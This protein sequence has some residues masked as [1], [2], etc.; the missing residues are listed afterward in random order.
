MEL[1]FK[2]KMYP[3]SKTELRRGHCCSFP[4]EMISNER[5]WVFNEHTWEIGI[6][7]WVRL[8]DLKCATLILTF[9]IQIFK[10]VLT[11]SL[12]FKANLMK[13]LSL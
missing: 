7:H 10:H 2:P 6:D 5:H 9:R 8:K 1:E 13:Q 3:Y 4:G 11:H 12:L